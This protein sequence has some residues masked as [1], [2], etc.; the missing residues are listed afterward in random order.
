MVEFTAREKKQLAEKVVVQVQLLMCSYCS[1]IAG[2]GS[3]SGA[4]PVKG[5][6]SMLV[7]RHR[8]S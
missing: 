2:G 6:T 5:I 3:P 8:R 1:D 4:H 7:S